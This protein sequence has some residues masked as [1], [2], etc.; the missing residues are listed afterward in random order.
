MQ[1][2]LRTR[3][4][5]VLTVGSDPKTV[6]GGAQMPTERPQ[7]ASGRLREARGGAKTPSEHPWEPQDSP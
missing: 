7:T 4:V 5:S 2:P 3:R 1:R 6:K